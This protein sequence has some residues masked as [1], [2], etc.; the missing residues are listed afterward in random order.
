MNTYSEK[1]KLKNW[2]KKNIGDKLFRGMQKSRKKRRP[3]AYGKIPPKGGRER[4]STT[5]TGRTKRNR[6]KKKI[7]YKLGKKRTN[8]RKCARK[9]GHC[10]LPVT[11]KGSACTSLGPIRSACNPQ[12]Q[13]MHFA[14]TKNTVNSGH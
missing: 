14:R 10:V 1:R 3:K 5:R 9:D 4:V 6:N 7:E 2:T 8:T 12:G 13:L 11:P